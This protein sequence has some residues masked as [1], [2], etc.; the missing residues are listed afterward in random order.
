MSKLKTTI[1]LLFCFILLSAQGQSNDTEAALYNIG[2]GAV[3]GS[4]GA[5]INKTPEEKL[6]KVVLKSLWQG[7][8]GGYV[9]FESKR[10]LR[11]AQRQDSW[12]LIWAAKILNA[13]GTSIKENA[14][15]N[16]DFWK[17]WHINFGF[18]RIEFLTEEKLKVRYKLKP[19][20]LAYTL[21][22]FFS[23]EFNLASSLKY[24]EFV[25]LANN[26]E[27]ING[28]DPIGLAYPEFIV[29][30]NGFEENFNLVTHE[31]MH[32]YQSNDFSIFNSYYQKPFKRWSEKNK[33]INWVYNY[34]YPDLHLI[35]LGSAYLIERNN[36]NKY[37]N[38]FF[39]HEAGYYSDTLF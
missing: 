39:E 11:T 17:K 18:N 35:L 15:E 31:I 7:A 38:N 6:G 13:G 5:I 12:E 1:I 33:T 27:P 23:F 30:E 2:F 36:A 32:L 28:I 25:F 34:L 26:L 21:S 9:T 10:L 24:G 37:Y 16:R 3:F 8:V 19:I 29:I 22:G 20:A 14:A 4:I